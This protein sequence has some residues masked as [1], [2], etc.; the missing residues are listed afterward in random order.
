MIWD[1]H[2]GLS[3][4]PQGHVPCPHACPQAPC[5]PAGATAPEANQSPKAFSK[6][7]RSRGGQCPQALGDK[8]WGQA[9]HHSAVLPVQEG[10][11]P[12]GTRHGGSRF[13]LV[14]HSGAGGWVRWVRGDMGTPRLCLLVLAGLFGLAAPEGRDGGAVPG[15]PPGPT[16]IGDGVGGAGGHGAVV[17]AGGSAPQS[18]GGQAVGMQRWAPQEVAR[19]DA[20]LPVGVAGGLGT[21]PTQPCPRVW[22]LQEK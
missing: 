13:P 14:P 4:S 1:G 11:R 18:S 8:G 7:P 12:P 2:V 22:V 19:G 3:A 6:H 21:P 20:G 16:G 17:A 5:Q 9:S 15:A 10:F